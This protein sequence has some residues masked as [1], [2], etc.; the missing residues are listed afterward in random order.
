MRALFYSVKGTGHVNPT[1]PLVRA[2]VARGHDVTYT[3]TPEWKE[4]IEAM[5]AR[6][7]NTG[8]GD[9]PFTTAAYH[10][11]GMFLRELLP[12]AAAVVPRLLE[13]ARELGPDLIV[14]DSCAPWAR[15]I[16]AVLGCPAVCSLSTIVPSQQEALEAFGAPETRVDAYNQEALATLKQRWGVDLSGDTLGFFYARDNLSYSCVELNPAVAEMPQRV[17]FVGPLIAAGG[18]GAR[19]LAEHGL[20]TRAELSGRKRVYVSMGT[21][22]GDMR[23]LGPAFFKPFIEAFGEREDWEIVISVGK[24][25]E[26]AGFG[27]VPSNV[28]IRKSVPQVALLP[29]VDVF[30][31]HAG[32]N[33]MHEA[34]FF[35]VPLVCI[36]VFGDQPLNASRVVDSGAGVRLAYEAISA[37]N[38]RAQVERVGTDPAFAGN[39][40]KLGAALRACGGI[41]R[42][43]QVLTDA[44]ASRPA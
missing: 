27:D 23:N 32:A 19:E 26:P 25:I 22:V 13:Q 7:R 41:D 16:G 8:E 14:Y 15:V 28:I 10:P 1:L 42:A 24:S 11:N 21:V 12:A 34:L 40:S 29:H 4:R 33:S 38:V 44:T 31:T 35:D 17:H 18:G 30:V 36:P 3:L 5:G 2:L 20:R 43:M 9:T 6:Y 39:A 37:A